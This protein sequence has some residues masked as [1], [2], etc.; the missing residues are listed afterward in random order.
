MAEFVEK[1]VPFLVLE[2]HLICVTRITFLEIS[3][4]LIDS[5]FCL[6]WLFL[7]DYSEKETEFH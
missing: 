5:V 2:G 3:V 1:S 6:I 4:V 7:I